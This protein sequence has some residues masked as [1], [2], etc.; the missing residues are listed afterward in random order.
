MKL[1]RPLI[2]IGASVSVPHTGDVY[3]D[4]LQRCNVSSGGLVHI[5]QF[6]VQRRRKV[7]SVAVEE[8][9]GVARVESV[10][11]PVPGIAR[12]YRPQSGRFARSAKKCFSL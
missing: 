2:F 6:C 11:G 5:C 9:S 10:R 4:F 8:G 3:G 12:F 1:L 7:N